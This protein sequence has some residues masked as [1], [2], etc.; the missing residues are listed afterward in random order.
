MVIGG[1]MNALEARNE[2]V[3]YILKDGSTENGARKIV[4]KILNDI[5]SKI[6]NDMFSG[7]ILENIPE[8]HLMLALLIGYFEHCIEQDT[9]LPQKPE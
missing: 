1:N 4:L 5:E 3:N 7:K 2:L 9:N 8:A 6:C